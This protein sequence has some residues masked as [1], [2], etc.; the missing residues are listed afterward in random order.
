MEAGRS[1]RG[2]GW[3]SYKCLLLLLKAVFTHSLRIVTEWLMNP[4]LFR[5][6]KMVPACDS[7]V[8]PNPMRS[9]QPP[10]GKSCSSISQSSVDPRLQD[11]VGWK[12]FGIYRLYKAEK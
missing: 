11:R 12:R 5:V 9:S 10:S 7:R 1:P 8:F 3:V 6:R 4:E 2:E